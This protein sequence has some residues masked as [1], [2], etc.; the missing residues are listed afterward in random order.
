MKFPN[1]FETLNDPKFNK[2]LQ[3]HKHLYVETTTH[4]M[5]R[6][7]KV[8]SEAPF[9]AMN[10]DEFIQYL[11]DSNYTYNTAVKYV[12]EWQKMNPLVDQGIIQIN[13]YLFKKSDI[14]R[15]PEN[16]DLVDK[17]LIYFLDIGN[18]VNF[19]F[20]AVTIAFLTALRSKELLSL[21]K[22]HIIEM[23]TGHE[24]IFLKRKNSEI[25]QPSYTNTLIN[26]LNSEFVYVHI[27]QNENMKMT[28]D[29]FNFSRNTLLYYL[30]N[31]FIIVNGKSPP[32]G[33]GLHS[34]RNY[35]ATKLQGINL[36][37]A[38]DFLGHKKSWTTLRYVKPS[39]ST[40]KINHFI[41]NNDF[42]NKLM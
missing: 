37:I 25:W 21:Q 2:E 39:I 11:I 22:R 29:I 35:W 10:K 7:T 18:L 27:N 5:M 9:N 17:L 30:K 24:T 23:Q 28:D 41:Q 33:F 20:L 19:K 13:H 1:F 12:R 6:E 8:W 42:Y 15:L 40:K 3:Q 34:I 38:K 16:L 14:E 4:I 31:T 32:K 36:G 26:V